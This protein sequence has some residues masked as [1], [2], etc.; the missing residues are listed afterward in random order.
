MPAQTPNEHFDKVLARLFE[1]VILGKTHLKI[2]RGIADALAAD[3]VIA[4]VCQVF[5]GTTINAHLDAAQMAAFK[6]F[7]SRHG[8]MSIEYLLGVAS[9]YSDSFQRATPQQVERITQTSREKIGK[10]LIAL[11]ALNSKRNRIL[12]HMEPTIVSD[13]QRL[14]QKTRVTFKDL[15]AIFKT[16]G[17]ILNELSV[18]YR[19]TTSLLELLDNEDFTMAIQLIAD[20]KHEQ[21]DRYEREFGTPA[22]FGRPSR[23]RSFA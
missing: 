8:S 11:E 23:P 15:E 14:A 10:Q 17:E 22:P 1:V 20:A 4:H 18:A 5:W 16:A 9:Q 6:L 2:G 3:P 21:A 19:D 7:D 13:P 12:A